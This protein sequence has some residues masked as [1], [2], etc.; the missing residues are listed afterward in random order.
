MSRK[1]SLVFGVGVNDWVGVIHLGGKKIREYKLW[2][3]MLERCFSEKYKQNY[4]TYNDATCSKDW[5][6]MTKF[7][8]DVSQM[9]GYG[10]KGWQLDK[11]I[12]V[13]GNKLYSKDTCCF[14]PQEVNYLL[15]KSDKA[16]GE[17]P[18]GV[19]FHKAS[20]KFHAR[21]KIN[22]KKKDLGRFSTPEEAF[23]AYKTAKEAHIKAVAT[24]WKDQ[25]DERVYQA[26]INYTVSIDD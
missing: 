22:G 4:P 1:R 10:L 21:L 17:W 25:L 8:E 13:K 15:T 19:Y 14:V 9:T 2:S 16:R 12:L 18:I 20:G 5:L 11:D 6:S 23:Q 7:I 26:L 24:K 3:C